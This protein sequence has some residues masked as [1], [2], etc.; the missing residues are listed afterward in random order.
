MLHWLCWKLNAKIVKDAYPIPRIAEMLEALHG[1]KWFSSL[2]LQS[3][4]LRVGVHEA[5]KPNTAMTTP[6]GLSEFNSMP[7]GLTNEP[8]TFQRL[9]GE[10]SSR[11]KSK[12]MPCLPR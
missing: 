6:F 12:D 11:L 10:I 4:I 8:T 2:D 9:M 5:D 7:F 1:A 3:G